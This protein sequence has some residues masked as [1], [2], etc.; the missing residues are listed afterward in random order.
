MFDE[1]MLL[2]DNLINNSVEYLDYISGLDYLHRYGLDIIIAMN[3]ESLRSTYS[4]AIDYG[5]PALAERLEPLLD[6][7]FSEFYN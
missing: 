6:R 4:A 5:I 7:Y 3:L 1:A 2:A